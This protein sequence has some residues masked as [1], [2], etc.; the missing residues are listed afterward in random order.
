MEIKLYRVLILA[1][2]RHECSVSCPSHTIP[3][4]QPPYP[5]NSGLG[6]LQSQSRHFGEDKSLFPPMHIEPQYLGHPVH[7]P[8]TILSLP[9]NSLNTKNR[10]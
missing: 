6:G 8:L 10:K 3:E 9:L 1:L 4:E 5:L 7:S 2:D